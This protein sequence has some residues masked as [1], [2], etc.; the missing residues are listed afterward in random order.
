MRS[1]YSR[2]ESDSNLHI[3]P[4]ITNDVIHHNYGGNERDP[5]TASMPR[6]SF[7]SLANIRAQLWF[8]FLQESDSFNCRCIHTRSLSSFI[9]HMCL[10]NTETL[11]QV[12]N[13]KWHT[14][15]FQLLGNKWEC[16]LKCIKKDL[17]L[18]ASWCI[19]PPT[20]Q[21]WWICFETKKHSWTNWLLHVEWC[22][23][24]DEG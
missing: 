15:F 24:K 17:A 9:L 22:M 20:C 13:H 11:I 1:C 19:A 21:K 14:W 10:A 5:A 7:D 3:I 2:D 18:V 16:S 8:L 23:G 6:C 12:N 4:I